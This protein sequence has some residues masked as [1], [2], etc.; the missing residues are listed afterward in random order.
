MKKKFLDKFLS[1]DIELEEKKDVDKSKDENQNKYEEYTIFDSMTLPANEPVEGLSITSWLATF[2]AIG[3][4]IYSSF[5]RRSYKQTRAS[6]EID[7]IRAGVEGM[8]DTRM[9]ENMPMFKNIVESMINEQLEQIQSTLPFQEVAPPVTIF[10]ISKDE[11]KDMILKATKVGE[12]FYPSDIANK[13]G[14]DLKTVIEVID[15]LKRE[16]NI[17]DSQTVD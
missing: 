6:T 12:S 14:L 2:P 4:S 11:I 10:D 7:P 9:A 16:G 1:R 17:S 13:F 5:G 8:V 15:E 3:P